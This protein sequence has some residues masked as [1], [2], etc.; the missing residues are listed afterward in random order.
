MS[1]MLARR[2]HFEC[3]MTLLPVVTPHA[4]AARV[5]NEVPTR[6]AHFRK[7]AG[8]GTNYQRVGYSPSGHERQNSGRKLPA[9]YGILPWKSARNEL[10][11]RQ[12]LQ[13]AAG[14]T[15]YNPEHADIR[16][17]VGVTWCS[18]D[19]Y[20]C[21][22]DQMFI[23]RFSIKTNNA[24]AR[25]AVAAPLWAVII[26]SHLTIIT[27]QLHQYMDSAATSCWSGQLLR[28]FEAFLLYII[29][30]RM[31]FWCSL[32][33]YCIAVLTCGIFLYLLVR[34][35]TRLSWVDRTN[36]GVVVVG[37]L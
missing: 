16:T 29:V 23:G 24:P 14:F 13:C 3:H 17:P 6:A 15:R 2:R 22:C 25:L 28:V 4:L 9:H 32:S 19:V 21:Q 7:S 37:W 11:R 27:N 26:S 30:Q 20:T 8:T 36:E 5:D 18:K 12:F 31:L 35:T 33:R 1:W 34:M 10:L